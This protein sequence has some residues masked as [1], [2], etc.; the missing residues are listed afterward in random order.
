MWGTIADWLVALGT[1][2]VAAVA[3]FQET[4][5]GWFYRPKLTATNW[6]G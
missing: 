1:L 5:R 3:V 4:I 6:L 2:T